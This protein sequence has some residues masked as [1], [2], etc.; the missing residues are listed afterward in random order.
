MKRLPEKGC[1]KK[2]LPPKSIPKKVKKWKSIYHLSRADPK[3]GGEYDEDCNYNL[4]CNYNCA[5]YS[6]PINKRIVSTECIKSNLF[7]VH[8]WHFWCRGGE[9]VWIWGKDKIKVFLK[10]S[11]EYSTM[12]ELPILVLEIGVQIQVR[13]NILSNWNWLFS[14]CHM[15]NISLQAL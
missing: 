5:F 2:K 4:N 6:H 11:M 15:N 14:L 13:T 1:P 9:L 10:K 3:G 7:T 8:F 12:V